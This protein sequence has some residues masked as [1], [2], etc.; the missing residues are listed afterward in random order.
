L[1]LR[2]VNGGSTW[3]A[4]S[5]PTSRG[6]AHV[7]F[8]DADHGW[9]V[10]DLGTVLRYTGAQGTGSGYDAMN[11]SI[12]FLS[13]AYPN[14]F[15]PST[16]LRVGVPRASQVSLDIFDILGRKTQTL[17]SGIMQPGEHSVLW[18]CPACPSGMYFVRVQAAGQSLQREL[19]LLK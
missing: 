3:T 13:P 4:E 15:N 7:T 5:S 1:I 2:T 18:N 17:V 14:P 19:I 8:V 11:P 6:L 9:A 10:G 16:T 12:F